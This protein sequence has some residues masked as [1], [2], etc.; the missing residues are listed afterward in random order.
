MLVAPAALLGLVL[1]STMPLPPELKKDVVVVKTP[2]IQGSFFG[3]PRPASLKGYAF[4][5]FQTGVSTG[6]A[7][8]ARIAHRRRALAFEWV[9]MQNG[10][11]FRLGP[12][13]EPPVDLGSV[14]C[15]WGYAKWSAEF[16]VGKTGVGMDV[17][18]ATGL[19]CRITLA[20]EE[21]PWEFLLWVDRPTNLLLPEFP[22]GGDLVRGDETYEVVSTNAIA[23]LGGFPSTRMTGTL[24]RKESAPVAAVERMPGRIIM[25][26]SLGDAERS[27][28]ICVGAAILTY[29]RFALAAFYGH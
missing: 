17:P 4:R 5:D 27:L 28:F 13:G 8:G 7:G 20:G 9:Q 26:S 19:D 25:R 12:E 24:F 14:A 29:D 6:E 2:A 21:E 18:G 10:F 15:Q 3:K 1:A 11:S 23:F 16:S 22:S